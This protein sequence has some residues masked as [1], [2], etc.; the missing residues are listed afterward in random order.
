MMQALA[1]STDWDSKFDA[2]AVTI[3]AARSRAAP[4]H[5]LPVFDT[6]PVS[7]AAPSQTT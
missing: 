6:G 3:T 7:Q 2:V 1:R 5:R 4:N